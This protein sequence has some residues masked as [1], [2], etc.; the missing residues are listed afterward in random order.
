MVVLS[1]VGT[2]DEKIVAGPIEE[3]STLDFGEPPHV[4]IVPGKMHF[5]EIESLA[6]VCGLEPGKIGD[7]TASIRRTAQV[8]VPR[9]A[10]KAKKALRS[11]RGSLNQ[12]Y[13]DS[14]RIV[15]SISRMRRASSPMGR[16]SSRCSAS[17]T[18]RA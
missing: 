14:S 1:R 7:N 4:A 11:A 8:L 5:S 9:Y 13:E 17:A 6:S 16:T 10:E 3:L 18:R 12:G 2:R 15:N